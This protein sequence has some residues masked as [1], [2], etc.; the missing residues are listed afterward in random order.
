M[1]SNKNLPGQSLLSR[2]VP[3]RKPRIGRTQGIGE[4]RE[5]SVQVTCK[6]RDSWREW[7]DANGQSVREVWLVFHKKHTGRQSVTYEASVEEALCV[8]WIDSLV[9]RLDDERYARKF[10]PRKDTGKWSE[11]N[12]KR[13]QRLVA[14]GRMTEA[15]LAKFAPIVQSNTG[16]SNKTLKVPG[17]LKE[18]LAKDQRAQEFFDHLAPSYRR[19]IIAWIGSAKRV[20]T[21]EK[22]LKET[23]GLL[24]EGK[25]LGM[26]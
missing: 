16:A 8:G 17:F 18:A 14:S 10:T 11:S 23:L 9:K 12:R 22:R 7:L 1:P 20:E 25:K 21:R 3:A 2:F 26:K 5:R 15:G 24:R 13:M 19:N 4:R 6:D